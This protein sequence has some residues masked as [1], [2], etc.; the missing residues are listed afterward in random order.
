MLE[1]SFG[2]IKNAKVCYH[3][4]ARNPNELSVTQGDILEVL[5][6]DTQWW[7]LR[8][9]SGQ[10]GYVPCN[11][12]KLTD[13]AERKPAGLLITQVPLHSSS[14]PII[15]PITPPSPLITQVPL[16]SSS[17]PITP[18]DS[19]SPRYHYTP[20][21]PIITHHHPPSP[22]ITPHDSS[23]PRYHYTPHH[24]PSSPPS[25][26]I[27]QVPLHPSIP[28]HPPSSPIITPPSLPITPH[29]SSSLFITPHHSSSLLITQVPLHPSIPHH[30]PSS[31]LITPITPYHPGTIR[32]PLFST[33]ASEK[34]GRFSFRTSNRFPR[35]CP[36]CRR[37]DRL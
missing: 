21:S 14:P 12:L 4:V 23:S 37:R 34:G 3:F 16:H 26:L 22:P 2:H 6:Q 18:H 33:R 24:P 36:N 19:S 20:P 13:H 17:P 30:H 1:P 9:R 25:P 28:H 32:L 35:G 7:R 10:E 15:T 31:P 8:S 11:I 27:T 29:H 5:A